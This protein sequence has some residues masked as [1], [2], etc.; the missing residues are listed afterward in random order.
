MLS[1]TES[2]LDS[3]FPLFRGVVDP[4]PEPG[5]K[6]LLESGSRSLPTVF[7]REERVDVE[8]P[9]RALHE[10]LLA[11]EGEIRD[12]D[13]AHLCA[14]ERIAV[15]IAERVELLDVAEL[16]A[17]LFADPASKTELER[18][19]LD[20]IERSEGKGGNPLGSCATVSTRGLSPVT[21]RI[22]ALSPT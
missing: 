7:P 12:G 8:P 6:L 2:D 1:L 21:A 13:H 10:R 19:V 22:A 11:D 20:G 15:E 5:Q 16:E 17:R 4:A 18:P 9:G 3:L 14:G